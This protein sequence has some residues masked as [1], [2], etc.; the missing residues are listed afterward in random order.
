MPASQP[1]PLRRIQHR[2]QGLSKKDK[3]VKPLLSTINGVKSAH[4]G[5]RSSSPA[6]GKSKNEM[7]DED[8][9]YPPKSSDDE[10]EGPI[11]KQDPVDSSSDSDQGYNQRRNRNIKSTVFKNPASESSGS[12]RLHDELGSFQK[13]KPTKKPK[14][15]YSLKDATK[16]GKAKQPKK[17]SGSILDQ[18][19]TPEKKFKHPD[20]S[21]ALLTLVSPS[22]P[23]NFLPDSELVSDDDPIPASKVISSKDSQPRQPEKLILPDFEDFMSHG[24]ESSSGPKGD[25]AAL[26]ERQEEEENR[27]KAEIAESE[28]E[29]TPIC[30]MCNEEV[31]RE[32]LDKHQK[33]GKMNIREQ[34]AFCRL[35]KR[36][37]ASK[38]ETEKGYPRIDWKALEGRCLSHKEFLGDILN[39][40]RPSH[41]R[42]IFKKKV[43]SGKN[44]TLLTSQDNLTPGYYG[45]RG[46]RVMTE[47][48]MRVLSSTIRMR[49]VED[50]LISARSYTGYVQSVLVPELTVRLIMEDMS[51]AEEKA[52]QVLQ[53]SVEIGELLYEETRDVVKSME[54]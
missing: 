41:Y 44:R 8:I 14:Q 42:E 4:R 38:S 17:T 6:M 28:V 26:R 18:Q 19:N 31:D 40:N 43:D 12:K 25:T 2:R 22:K 30:P 50:R 49:A 24:E 29:S 13:R 33:R 16:A 53:E 47:F 39:D 48:I 54:E 11:S 5:T 51:I 1:N 9:R 10:G 52:R 45:P 35:H 7:D 36:L 34:T 3:T 27:L 23:F 37:T 15:T 46:L 21:S 20:Y 32:L